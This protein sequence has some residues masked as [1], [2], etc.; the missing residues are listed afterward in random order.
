MNWY[1][2]T[3]I[4]LIGRRLIWEWFW[5]VDSSFEERVIHKLRNTSPP[6]SVKPPP[7]PLLTALHN[8]W[9]I[10]LLLQTGYHLRKLLKTGSLDWNS[11]W[12]SGSVDTFGLRLLALL[13][14]DDSI[15]WLVWQLN[16][17]KSRRGLKPVWID[18]N[19]SWCW[20]TTGEGVDGG[21]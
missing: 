14:P 8:S 3:G 17:S 19:G 20:L 7:N 11:D 9:T 13:A 18:K 15:D 21:V 12:S 10:P 2:K 16:R 5:L 6:P 4:F 1:A